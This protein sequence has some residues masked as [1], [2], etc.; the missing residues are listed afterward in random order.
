MKVKVILFT[1]ILL[2]F[3]PVLNRGGT[4][5]NKVFSIRT[6]E[7][8]A[9]KPLFCRSFLD[10][11]GYRESRNNYRIVNSYGYL[12][13]YQFSMRTIRGLGFDVTKREFLR[14]PELQEIVMESYL[15][16]NRTVLNYYI[17]RYDG[18]TVNS[19]KITESG[20]LAAAHLAGAGGIIQ[21][22][23]YGKDSADG[24]GTKIS[25]Y[26]KEFS[27]YKLVVC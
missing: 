10:A 15:I 22:F 12:G 3:S 24:F 18:K 7:I 20:I 16:H 5:G 21:Y 26:L 13:K 2:L 27:K 6:V 4:S 9:K 14:S 23:E 8:V 17:K 19:I 1:T 11:I 25:T